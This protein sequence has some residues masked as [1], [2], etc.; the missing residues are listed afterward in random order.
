MKNVRSLR[1]LQSLLWLSVAPLGFASEPVLTPA[2]DDPTCTA[3]DRKYMARAFEFAR[4]SLAR[5]D[6]AIGAVLVKDGKIICESGNSIFTDR[7]LTQHGETG[8]ISHA[9][10]VL[11]KSLWEGSTLYTSLEPCIM[12]CGSIHAAGIKTVVYG[13]TSRQTNGALFDTKRLRVREIYQRYGWTTGVRGPL[14]DEEQ[15]K[16]RAETAARAAKAKS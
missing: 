3:E 10:P 5:G 4:K 8:L 14:M 15:L 12:C 2:A 1:L 13:G 11:E 16:I 7:D 9:S 6:N